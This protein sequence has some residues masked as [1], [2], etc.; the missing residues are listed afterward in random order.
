MK[1]YLSKTE[2]LHFFC[3]KDLPPADL[4]RVELEEHH[5]MRW[6]EV[7]FDKTLKPTLQIEKR[8]AKAGSTLYKLILLL[9]KPKPEIAS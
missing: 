3:S 4:L 7:Y 9:K 5:I 2:L 8:A 6:V 1:F